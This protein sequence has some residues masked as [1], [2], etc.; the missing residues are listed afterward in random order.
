MSADII[1][2]L[3]S[4]FYIRYPIGYFILGPLICLLLDI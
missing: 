2:A 3:V 1:L 4:G